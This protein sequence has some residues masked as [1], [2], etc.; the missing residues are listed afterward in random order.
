MNNLSSLPYADRSVAALLRHNFLNS[1]A[2]LAIK[3]ATAALTYAMFVVLARTMGASGYGEFAFGFALATMV[4][5]AAGMGQ[6][7][8]I[9]RFWPEE[10]GREAPEKAHQALHAGATLTLGAALIL[11]MLVALTGYALS[12]SGLAPMSY[13]VAAGLL[14]IPMAL[15][16][17]RSSALRA[18]GSV[19]VAL[20]PRDLMWRAL[21][22]ALAIL[23][24]ALGFRLDG[25]SALLLAALVLVGVLAIQAR[26]AHAR[27]YFTGFGLR[28]VPAYWRARGGM[29]IWFLIS[30]LLD[31]AA[32]NLDIVLVGLFVAA[33]SAGIYFNAFRT[34]GLMTLFMFAITLVIAPVVSKHFHAGDI[35]KAQAVTTLCAWAGFVFSLGIFAVFVFF[36]DQ[37]LALFGPTYS[38]AKLVLILLAFGLLFDAAT[39]PTRIVMMMTG[40]E[41]A[42]VAIFGTVMVTGFFFQLATIPIYGI[43]GAAVVNAI[44]RIVA[45]IAIAIWARRKIGLDT[46]L[47]GPIG[48][49][50]KHHS[51]PLQRPV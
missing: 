9:L 23:F 47:L 26:I 44:A 25:G 2:S 35:R 39:G 41:R 32:L 19:F 30:T 1:L 13:L 27:G 17:F 42:Y 46:T 45:Q 8:A 11:A 38:D 40:H 10:M 48:F 6:Q 21:V 43:L 51:P 4:A 18:Q 7:T 49:S 36:G 3:L 12:A 28:G 37:I 22:P 33:E 20:A 24:F 29:S 15:A 34:A 31:S 16:E 50:D 5:I 14:V